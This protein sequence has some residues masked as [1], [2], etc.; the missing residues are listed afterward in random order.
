MQSFGTRP[1]FRGGAM[2]YSQPR[3]QPEERLHKALAALGLGSRRQIEQW[4]TAGRV[5]ING[6]VAELG[7]RYVPGD[8][9]EIDGRLL[10]LQPRPRLHRRVIVYNKPEG[11][12]VTRF[13]PEGRP[14]V[15]D[16]LPSLRGS[17]WIAVGRLD[18][19]SSGL[20]LLTTD[21]D[22]AN[23]L[24][25][26]S[27]A[28]EREYAVRV[29][30]EMTQEMGQRLL[31]GV[32]LEDGPAR[33]DAIYEVGGIG[34]NKWYHV[35]I[36]EGRQREVRRLWEAVGAQVSRL[37]RVRYGNVVLGDWLRLG[38][39]RELEQEELT[40]LLALAGLGR[41]TSEV[42]PRTDGRRGGVPQSR[43]RFSSDD[44]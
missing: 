39:W 11:E 43:R 4:I 22:L 30:G 5:R 9:I 28:I 21:G 34:L 2:R 15:F 31:D 41:E 42:E 35:I 3:E 36:R 40:G 20:L 6:R 12:V 44:R 33:F 23:R 7:E 32:S 19:N 10:R 37:I 27:Q 8:R 24:M 13:D 38:R 18:I 1:R 14:R 25:H 16:H 26:P 29:F 17:R